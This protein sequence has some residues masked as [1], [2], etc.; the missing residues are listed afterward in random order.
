MK[1]ADIIHSLYNGSLYNDLLLNVI[2]Y[3]MH[4]II[5]KLVFN[6]M[7]VKY[8][9]NKHSEEVIKVKIV[10]INIYNNKYL[11]TVEIGNN[12][13]Y[14]CYKD[15]SFNKDVLII[16]HDIYLYLKDNILYI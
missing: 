1:H 15:F 12:I 4:G 13:C 8:Y 10:G 5:K 14:L 9:L 11:L 3:D 16:G 2:D 6:A 7:W